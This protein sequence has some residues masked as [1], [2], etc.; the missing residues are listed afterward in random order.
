MSLRFYK[1]SYSQGRSQ[2]CVEVADLDQGDRAVRDSRHPQDTM[3]AF[4]SAE[5]AALLK[6]LKDDRF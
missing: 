5:W 1:S 2:N 4:G 6:Q 3:L